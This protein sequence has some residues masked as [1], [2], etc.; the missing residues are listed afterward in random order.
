MIVISLN[1][2]PSS[3]RLLLS[4]GAVL[5]AGATAL[6]LGWYGASKQ[7]LVAAQLPWLISGGMVGA[8]L[9]ALGVVLLAL[10]LRRHSSAEELLALDEALAEVRELASSTDAL[11]RRAA[12]RRIARGDR[13]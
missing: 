4:V 11:R 8:A 9:L 13:A 7:L 5:L 6:V 1:I 10:T 3:G 12:R 2:K